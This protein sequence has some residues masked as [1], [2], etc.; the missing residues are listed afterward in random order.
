MPAML[1]GIRAYPDNPFQFDFIV[2]VGDSGLEGEAF[3]IEAQ[4]LVRYFLASLTVPEKNLWVNLSPYEKERI[5]AGDFG[6]T[7]MGRDLL[8]QDY[9]LKQITASLTH[10]E[11]K[12]GKVFW[13]KVYKRSYELFG[14]TNIPA[15]TFNKVWI[16]PAK[17][18]VYENHDKAFIV[19]SK[20]KVM[21][22]ED[23][24]A[25]QAK[26]QVDSLSSAK[27][28]QNTNDQMLTTKNSLSSQIAREV[29]LP[30]LEK[31]VNEGKNFAVLRQVYSSFIL[32]AWFKQTLKD[33]IINKKYSDQSK[34]KGVDV[35]DKDVH[36][37]IYAQYLV[38][39]KKGVC[40]IMKVEFDPYIRKAIPRKYFS[41]GIEM[42]THFDGSGIIEKTD[43]LGS[44]GSSS[45]RVVT[46]GF[47]SSSDSP[48]KKASQLSDES[49]H[50]NY[51]DHHLYDGI[52]NLFGVKI[53]NVQG[54]N[55][56]EK[57]VENLAANA[58]TTEVPA[59]ILDAGCGLGMSLINAKYLYGS[60]IDAYGID[61]KE[62]RFEDMGPRALEGFLSEYGPDGKEMYELMAPKVNFFKGP[63]NDITTKKIYG[64]DGQPVHMDLITS[65]FV[66]QYL[67]DPLA[68]W[69]NLFHQLNDRGTF[70]SQFLFF[71]D[72]QGL[73]NETAYILMFEQMRKAGIDINLTVKNRIVNGVETG[74]RLLFVSA[75]RHGNQ[76]ITLNM[77]PGSERSITLPID[78]GR[79][80]YTF[81]SVSYVP[82]G[83]KMV[84]VR[85][86]PST[87]NAQGS[88]ISD[89]DLLNMRSALQ[90]SSSNEKWGPIYQ[91]VKGAQGTYVGT[92]QDFSWIANGDFSDGVLVDFNPFV[93]E[94]FLPIKAALISVSGNR[95]EYLNLLQGYLPQED[96]SS[97]LSGVAN[98]NARKNEIWQRMIKVRPDLESN[99][100]AKRFW[101]EVFQNKSGILN[102]SVVS[103]KAI[104][105]SQD[106]FSWLGSEESFLKIKNMV[107]AGKIHFLTLDWFGE[108]SEERVRQF[109]QKS[110][111]SGQASVVHVSNILEW[112]AYSRM[113]QEERQN[114]LNLFMKNI[115]AF[116][117]V[118]DYMLINATF[119]SLL[120][121]RPADGTRMV[122]LSQNG[123]KHYAANDVSSA[124]SSELRNFEQYLV[125]QGNSQE[126]VA[127]AVSILQKYGQI[128]V[129][130][131]TGQGRLP[132]AVAGQ[133]SDIGVIG[134]DSFEEPGYDYRELWEQGTLDGLKEKRENLVI[135]KGEFVDLLYH[136]PDGTID[137]L[138]VINPSPQVANFFEKW[139]D[140]G[141]LRKKMKPGGN[142]YYAPAKVD[143]AYFKWLSGFEKV[144][145]RNILGVAIDNGVVDYGIGDLHVLSSSSSIPAE[146]KDL[147][148]SIIQK[149]DPH[150]PNQCALAT[151]EIMGIWASRLN[152]GFEPKTIYIPPNADRIREEELGITHEIIE[153]DGAYVID[154]QLLQF[155]SRS[156]LDLPEDFFWK[157]IFTIEEYYENV[158]AFRNFI[159]TESGRI[160]VSRPA[161]ENIILAL[162]LQDPE[163]NKARIY[164]EIQ[165]VIQQKKQFIPILHAL[166]FNDRTSRSTRD[167]IGDILLEHGRALELNDKTIEKIAFLDKD[168]IWK[169]KAVV[170]TANNSNIVVF[171]SERYQE[172]NGNIMEHFKAAQGINENITRTLGLKYQ[173]RK[174]SDGKFVITTADFFSSSLEMWVFPENTL[175]SDIIQ[176]AYRALQ[177]RIKVKMQLAGDG[178]YTVSQPL[179][180]KLA[181]GE[182][183]F[184]RKAGEQLELFNAD[185]S[186]ASSSLSPEGLGISSSPNFDDTFSSQSWEV[187]IDSEIPPLL[188]AVFGNSEMR[189]LFEK[190]HIN[191]IGV[192]DS[193]T[194][195]GDIDI[196]GYLVES[197]TRIVNGN[198]VT[199]YSLGVLP[200]ASAD[201]IFHEILHAFWRNNLDIQQYW[202]MKGWGSIS[203]RDR[204][205]I[206]LKLKQEEAFCDL[207]EWEMFVDGGIE[208]KSLLEKEGEKLFRAERAA[209]LE[210]MK[211]FFA[212]ILRSNIELAKVL[213]FLKENTAKGNSSQLGGIDLNPTHFDLE[214]QGSASPIQFDLKNFENIEIDG[215]YPVIINIAPVTNLPLLLGVRQESQPQL[216]LAR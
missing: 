148:R 214:R 179:L 216:S 121:V 156:K 44:L 108:S 155:K 122:I 166:Y 87:P 94:A 116:Y 193:G 173:A 3:N 117:P 9:L 187:D 140:S 165:N 58:R 30:E 89:Q 130:A 70:V 25:L 201:T 72:A 150:H 197:G 119:D 136:I 141:N 18:K 157:G 212:D 5:I 81:K 211:K 106:V 138:S 90:W 29:L 88:R 93:T 186:P 149:Y 99:E 105:E 118:E 67:S 31:E 192:V 200:T 175:T 62:S 164:Q 123:K 45:L 124:I 71:N 209:R 78:N 95:Q 52:L 97:D 68:A 55:P 154:T 101:D 169:F 23:Y 131:G 65:F 111:I 174:A 2:D 204:G 75:V 50:T 172:P 12:T 53:Q 80:S 21:L 47:Q 86:I 129:D 85:N 146:L 73:S 153:I 210:E 77:K 79:R 84:S 198:V 13:D 92:G 128:Y 115:K 19:E 178:V 180:N 33:S 107:Q 152:Y 8:A 28:L 51:R 184:F 15:N 96:I 125:R 26:Q 171:F 27:P 142:V 145:Q 183:V 4:K 114:K 207:F 17:A 43:D 147:A 32:A 126:A 158:P 113:T 104:E 208:R 10:P 182:K 161:A 38:A 42:R 39:Y 22:E 181:A 213:N 206:D 127:K 133:N 143:Q 35:D 61:K 159:I 137:H 195:H 177:Q 98:S 54:E 60:L 135:L 36:Q 83:D 46:S 109:L 49:D 202:N 1:R 37:K 6:E 91:E 34:V 188:K 170:D 102:W 144:S 76:E 11:S 205:Q 7:E 190:L 16:V 120:P 196:G 194:K 151:N 162:D 163:K 59:K 82:T 132:L 189:N 66:L 112:V 191:R 64:Q 134:F 69:L 48:L 215:L 167:L 56:L 63:E 57:I 160:R 199:T 100:K 103:K 20:L 203:T 176:G 139:H 41:G 185:G 168:G 24:V 74:E 40:D 14:T 110:Q